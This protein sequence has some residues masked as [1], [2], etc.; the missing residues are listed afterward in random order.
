MLRLPCSSSTRSFAPSRPRRESIRAFAKVT[1]VRGNARQRLDATVWP[2]PAETGAHDK[3]RI[4]WPHRVGDARSRDALRLRGGAG[5]GARIAGHMRDGAYDERGLAQE[6][7]GFPLIDA[8]I[9]RQP[10]FASPG[11]YADA[12]AGDPRQRLRNSHLLSIAPTAPYRFFASTTTPPSTTAV[13]WT[14]QRKKSEQ[15]APIRYPTSRTSLAPYATR[16]ATS[17]KLPR[18]S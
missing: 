10:R 4:G 2:C 11:F 1:K 18:R 16:S 12:E 3:R 9:S 8:R 15:A 17:Y 6:K 7:G 13:S 5:R 14:Y